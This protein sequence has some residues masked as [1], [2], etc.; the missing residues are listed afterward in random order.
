MDDMLPHVSTVF[1]ELFE[2][3][4]SVKQQQ[5]TITNYGALICRHLYGETASRG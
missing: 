3:L 2:E 1:K 4:K 5:W